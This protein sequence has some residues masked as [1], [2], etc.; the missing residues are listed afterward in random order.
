MKKRPALALLIIGLMMVS[1]APLIANKYS[2]SDG[3]RGFITGLGIGMELLAAYM[4][5][6]IKRMAN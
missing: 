1:I 3:V 5:I 2:L 4:L 6:R